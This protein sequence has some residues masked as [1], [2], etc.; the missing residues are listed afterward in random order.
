MTGKQQFIKNVTI[1]CDTREQEN[2][3]ILNDLD[4]WGVTIIR[5]IVSL[6]SRYAKM[7]KRLKYSHFNE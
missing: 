7:N 6:L 5:T 1:L 2:A 4:S 3:H